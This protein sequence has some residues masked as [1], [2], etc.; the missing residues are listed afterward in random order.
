MRAILDTHTWIWWANASTKLSTHARQQIHRSQVLG[1]SAI[2]CLEV[3]TLVEKNRLKLD[4]DVLIWI[5]QALSLPRIQFLPL[6]PEICVRATQLGNDFH[7]DPADR[8][9][10]ATTL[11]QGAILITK[12]ERIHTSQLVKAIW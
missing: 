4:R 9:L 5:K 11:E 1:V 2:S 8:I 6:T 7:G 12:D 3:A 10:V